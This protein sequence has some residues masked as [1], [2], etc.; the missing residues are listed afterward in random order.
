MHSLSIIGIFQ[1]AFIALYIAGTKKI[2]LPSKYL[3]SVNLLVVS[4][5]I[6]SHLIGGYKQYW[7]HIYVS[8]LAHQLIFL[9]G[10]LLYFYVHSHLKK[11]KLV[12][13]PLFFIHVIPFIV[14]ISIAI[15]VVSNQRYGWY[16][17][18]VSY[19]ANLIMVIQLI[20]YLLLINQC[21]Q[22]SVGHGLFRFL[23]GKKLN[24]SFFIRCLTIN[25]LFIFAHR[26]FALVV[27]NYLKNEKSYEKSTSN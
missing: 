26:S 18:K 22:K 16:Y 8:V 17:H 25:L 23:F 24:N 19:Y 4:F 9:T 5:L 6:V 3:I 21:I 27:W 12:F 15:Y 13:T 14:F 2:V 7:D 10:P 20:C 11:Q 1:S